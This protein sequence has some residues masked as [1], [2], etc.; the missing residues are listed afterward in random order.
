VFAGASARLKAG[1]VNF[2]FIIAA[3]I[4]DV[5]VKPAEKLKT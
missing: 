4:A 1:S 5:W 3:G 2:A